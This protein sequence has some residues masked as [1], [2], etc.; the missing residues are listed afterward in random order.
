MTD[1][2]TNTSTP[3]PK[4]M[5]E[6]EKERVDNLESQVKKADAPEL[7][8]G[9]IIS[10]DERRLM[11]NV[12]EKKLSK[13]DKEALLLDSRIVR[14]VTFSTTYAVEA[15]SDEAAIQAVKRD[16][17]KFPYSEPTVDILSRAATSATDFR[18]S[19]DRKKRA[20]DFEKS[21]KER[22]EREA[23]ATDDLR[24]APTNTPPHTHPTTPATAAAKVEKK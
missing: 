20:E 12:D 6:A 4:T 9:R 16:P 19:D 8:T 17:S 7:S 15:A 22:V 24:A 11:S 21:E 3:E 14:L 5:V 18:N 1:T 23:K 10:S 2:K 13:E